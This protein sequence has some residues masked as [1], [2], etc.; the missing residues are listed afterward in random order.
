MLCRTKECAPSQPITNEGYATSD[1]PAAAPAPASRCPISPMPA[2]SAPPGA[3]LRFS[4]TTRQR[5]GSARDGFWESAPIA[6]P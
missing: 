5:P 6:T 1:V 3:A 2:P 4:S